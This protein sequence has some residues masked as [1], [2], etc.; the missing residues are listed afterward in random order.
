MSSLSEF[1]LEL[2]RR[3]KIVKWSPTEQD[4]KVIAQKVSRSQATDHGDLCKI[5]SGVCP[6]TLQIVTEGIDNSDLRT[7]LVLATAVANQG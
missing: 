1:K 7:L 5:V 6:G 2:E 3:L 4:I